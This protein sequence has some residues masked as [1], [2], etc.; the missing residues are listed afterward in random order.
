MTACWQETRN[1]IDRNTKPLLDAVGRAVK[2]NTLVGLESRSRSAEHHV[3]DA[4][5]TSRRRVDHVVVGTGQ[6]FSS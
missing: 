5:L 1:K 4:K 6:D 3:G 2:Q